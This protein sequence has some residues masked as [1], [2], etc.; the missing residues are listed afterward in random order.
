[1]LQLQ[2]TLQRS[3]LD[4]WMDMDRDQGKPRMYSSAS[5]RLV[6]CFFIT[7]AIAAAVLLVVITVV[8][9]PGGVRCFRLA[10]IVH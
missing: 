6:V 5:N 4:G 9:C 3:G 1:M 7:V 2:K 10:C 8:S